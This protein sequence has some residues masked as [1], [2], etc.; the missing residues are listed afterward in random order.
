MAGFRE[1]TNESLE[2][3]KEKFFEK[4]Q[5]NKRSL[6][7]N[8]A[9]EKKEYANFVF[10]YQ[11]M[12]HDL[13]AIFTEISHLHSVK[14]SEETQ[15]V[16]SELIPILTEYYTELSQDPRIFKAYQEALERGEQNRSLE[17]AARKVLTDGI[18]DFRLNGV[19]LPEQEKQKV[20]KIQIQLSEQSNQFSQN[21]LNATNAYEKII[22][23]PRDIEG[24][25]ES[26][27]ATARQ[28]NSTWKFTLQYPSYIAYMNNGP[29]RKIREELY[30]AYTTRAPENGKRIL[31]ILSLRKELANIL[32]FQS[33]AEFS[34][35]FK[36]A[37]STEEILSFLYKLGDKAKPKAQEEWNELKDFARS[38]GLQE[39]EAFDIPY[40]SEW[41][42]RERFEYDEESYRPYFEKT[43]VVEGGFRFLG[44]F[45]GISFQ[46]VDAEVWDPTVQ[47]FHIIKDGELVGRLYTDL[48]SR[49]NKK[50]GAWMQ[51][52]TS[53]HRIGKEI[54]LPSAFIV[55]N[56]PPSSKDSPSLLRPA[57]VV[58]FFHEMGHAL[59]HLLTEVEHPSVSGIHGV[60]WDAVEFPSQFFENFV[61][62]RE[63][64]SF[65]AF[66]FQSG[67]PLPDELLKKLIGMKNFQSALGVLRQL[68]F[69]IFDLKLHMQEPPKEEEE[70]QNI[71]DQVR[72][73]I[74]VVK[75]PSYN[76]F[77]N[78]F[79]HIFAGG[80][81]AG[82]Y[83]Y[84]WAELL[85]ANAFLKVVEKGIL[86][87]DLGKQYYREILAKGGSEPAIQ[88]FRNFYGKD[89]EVEPLLRLLS[90]L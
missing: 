84:K 65:F 69:A 29:N 18:R 41:M 82:Y 42:K 27:L 2:V 78:G 76:R 24:I 67:E 50:S 87:S 54:E 47:V 12:N 74:A 20:K 26:D 17:I 63:S 37:E 30:K 89:P 25:P 66:H 61:Y 7:V 3:K 34:L 43:A 77:Q 16:Y 70:V 60:E 48:E 13:D 45:L 36:M 90:I 49:R 6:E 33:Y 1:F 75:P 32:G 15:K 14:N 40:Y 80:Y 64:L 11:K 62:E 85:S 72:S 57:D 22:T 8:L 79:S 19:D 51:N 38:K 71:L 68:E 5:E 4:L 88:L 10:P 44:Q 46:K 9:L 52:W 83:S 59:H 23:D 81:A 28:D 86:Q 56:F 35:A 31:E 58:T 73:E 55:A 53:R 39:L 21:L